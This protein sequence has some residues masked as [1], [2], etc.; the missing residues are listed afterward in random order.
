MTAPAS[1]SWFGPAGFLSAIVAFELYWRN[2]EHLGVPFSVDPVW[3]LGQI[4]VPLVL[5]AFRGLPRQLG[6]GLLVG[7]LG[8]LLVIGL[9]MAG[10][11]ILAFAPP[12]T[13]PPFLLALV[14]VVPMLILAA[15][16]LV[17]DRRR[18]R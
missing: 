2:A 17:W 7:W 6:F 16:C 11:G 13:A 10:G 3:L 9:L 4:G 15:L 18:R 12:T 1:P 5:M 14:A 8:H